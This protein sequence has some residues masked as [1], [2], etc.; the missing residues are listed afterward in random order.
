MM[1]HYMSPDV[2]TGLDDKVGRDNIAVSLVTE[3][4]VTNGTVFTRWF[5]YDRDKL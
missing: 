3:I 2:L 4:A 5:K 1:I